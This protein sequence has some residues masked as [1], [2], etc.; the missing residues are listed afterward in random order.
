MKTQACNPSIREADL[1]EY[2]QSLQFGFI[3]GDHVSKKHI[4]TGLERGEQ[5]CF[6]MYVVELLKMYTCVL[7]TE[8]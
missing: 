1:Q 4:N 2:M 3:F 7:L 5:N 6:L 8:C